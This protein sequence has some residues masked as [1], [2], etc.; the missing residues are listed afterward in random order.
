MNTV[1]LVATKIIGRSGRPASSNDAAI[2][3]IRATR[4]RIEGTIRVKCRG[5]YTTDQCSDISL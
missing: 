2:R 4:E 1:F 5:G 3:D